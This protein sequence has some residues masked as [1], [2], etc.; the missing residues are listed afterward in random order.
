MDRFL[1][2]IPEGDT[3]NPMMQ[4]LSADLAKARGGKIRDRTGQI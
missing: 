1:M 4:P 3:H 2:A